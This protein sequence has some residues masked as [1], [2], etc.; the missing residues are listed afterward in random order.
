[1]KASER[2]GLSPIDLRAKAAAFAKKTV[3][4]QS[5]SFQRYGVWADWDAP[6]LTL[7][8]EY[9]AAQLDVFGAMCLNGHVY[10][11]FK[12]VHWSP[13]SRTALAEAE[14]E[15]PEG[16]TSRSC[17]VAFATT[18]TAPCLAPFA[19]GLR[20]AVWTTTPWTIPA[21]LAVAVNPTMRISVVE[22]SRT[23]RLLVATSLVE[24]LET[25]LGLETG[26]F[27]ELASF[28]G[29]EIAVGTTYRHPL[30]DR[31]SPVLEGGDYISA[32]AGTGLVHTAPGHGQEDY[33]IG[34]KHGLALLSPVD[35]AGRFTAEAGGQFEGLDVLGDG[36]AAVIDALRENGS[37]L[38]EEPYAHKYPYDWRTKKP[39]IFRATEQW[40]ASVD[41]FRDA[42]MGAI[43]TVKWIP[44]LGKKR[45]SA[46][47]AS[48]SDW[49]ISRQVTLIDY[50]HG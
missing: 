34:I 5:A 49:C 43:D 36:N 47:T 13:S 28:S 16:H 8:P 45:I 37:L 27:R 10:R 22:S 15:Y 32:D 50:V 35:D 41:N 14:L 6:Y 26:G 24:S 38:K 33:Q 4:K 23:G 42:A 21:N 2:N 3:E 11:G 48:R 18:A 46:M 29:A 44:A 25:T 9:E 30:C 1:M 40:F 31:V 19:E 12:P 7:Q 17:Y 39:T 20:I